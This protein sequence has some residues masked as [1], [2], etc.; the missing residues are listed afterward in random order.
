[1]TWQSAVRQL[2]SLVSRHL[3]EIGD[4]PRR[5]RPRIPDEFVFRKL[6]MFLRAGCSWETFDELCRGSAVSGR[7]CRRRFAEWRDRGVFELVC[8]ELRSELPA[9]QIAHLDAMFI[10]SRGGGEDLVGLTRHGKGSK[11]QAL[12]DEESR[13]LMFQLTSANPNESTITGSLIEDV[14]SLPPIVV[15]DKAYDYD[16][17]RDAFDEL[18]STLVSPHRADRKKPPRDQE[19][20]GRLYKRRW[21]VERLFSWLAAWRRLATRWERRAESYWQ[22]LCLGIGLIYIRRNN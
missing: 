10:R 15:A 1:M 20:I 11:F 5:G 9:A 17:L 12:C 16:F 18:D 3:P 2:W 13:P 4:R 19:H 14:E 7:T 21:A 8:N 6:V 22:W